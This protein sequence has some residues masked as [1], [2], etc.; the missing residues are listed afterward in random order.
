MDYYHGYLYGYVF[1]I[2]LRINIG[3]LLDY[4]HGYELGYLCRISVRINRDINGISYRIN[5]WISI[6]IYCLDIKEYIGI[7]LDYYHGYEYGYVF[8]DISQDKYG[9]TRIAWDIF[10]RYLFWNMF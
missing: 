9:Y 5:H 7:L 1:W 4:Y 2:S 10:V 3:I 8:L 6:W